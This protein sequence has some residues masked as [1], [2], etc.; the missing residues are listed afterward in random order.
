MMVQSRWLIAVLGIVMVITNT[1][2]LRDPTRPPG[3]S[4]TTSKKNVSGRLVLNAI[5]HSKT[6]NFAIINGKRL[7]VGD[8]IL[9][10]KLLKIEK[11]AVYLDAMDGEIKLSII[12]HGSKAK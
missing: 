10:S 2:A 4:L 9:G 5:I 11:T 12:H 6:R 1:Y 3:V 7:E 8:M